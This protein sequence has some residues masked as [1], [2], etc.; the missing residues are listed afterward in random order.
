MNIGVLQLA[1]MGDWV[2]TMPLVANLRSK[3]PD[4]NITPICDRRVSD[5]VTEITD[6]TPIALPIPERMLARDVPAMLYSM[7]HRFLAEVPQFDLIIRCNDTPLARLW[8]HILENPFRQNTQDANLRTVRSEAL[9]RILP[10]I[11]SRLRLH[12]SDL[13]RWRVAD[14]QTI[15]RSH[16]NDT[17][18]QIAI[19]VGS[20]GVERAWGE[21]RLLRTIQIAS[22]SAPVTLIGS[23]SE[24][25]FA[26]NIARQIDLNRNVTNKV[27]CWSI[28]TLNSWLS[29]TG[30]VCV[31]LDTGSLHLAA[32][33]GAATFGCYEG[34]AVPETTGAVGSCSAGVENEASIPIDQW[35]ISLR[36]FLVAP[37][38]FL[39]ENDS[40]F[41]MEQTD[42]IRVLRAT[43][44]TETEIKIVNWLID[45]VHCKSN[46]TMR[47]LRDPWRSLEQW[48]TNW[49]NRS[50][51][52]GWEFKE[53]VPESQFEHILTALHWSVL[54]SINRPPSLFQRSSN[55]QEDRHASVALAR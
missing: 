8:Q 9:I 51:E 5:L 49:E 7:L 17:V 14:S 46:C 1:R 36:R 6:T 24:Q 38:Q 55:K 44:L 23:E 45:F 40:E 48:L 47:D 11:D 54:E 25:D 10:L 3:Y 42:R 20:G 22:D 12:I 29:Q 2:Q 16:W 35:E 19:A 34:E 4:A 39:P 43:S 37:N 50:N 41:V 26:G 21:D 33:S 13:W 30:V 32:L 31:A 28:K 15:P 27:G 18:R 53:V 52:P